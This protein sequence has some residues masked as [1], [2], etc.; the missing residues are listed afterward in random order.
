MQ[1]L[2]TEMP[3]F[4]GDCPFW[5]DGQCRLMNGDHCERF[6]L[7]CRERDTDECPCLI[8]AEAYRKKEV[9]P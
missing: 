9:A 8:T 4:L 3:Y 2:V 7:S 1:I 6:D 5:E